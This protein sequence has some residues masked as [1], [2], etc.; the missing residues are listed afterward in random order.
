MITRA[1]AFPEVPMI[2]LLLQAAQFY[3]QSETEGTPDLEETLQRKSW[4]SGS[5]SNS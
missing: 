3:K 2:T 5:L 4:K 1:W